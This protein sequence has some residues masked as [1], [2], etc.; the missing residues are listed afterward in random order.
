MKC[1]GY[2]NI[3]ENGSVRFT[4]GKCSLKWDEI[5]IRIRLDIPDELFV[6]PL[7]EAR[8]EVSKDIVPK[9]QPFDLILN[10]KDLIEESTGAKINFSIIEIETEDKNVKGER[11]K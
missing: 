8:I 1:N 4:K 2:L 11:E 7:I 5:A 6:R 9:P 3:N 10:T